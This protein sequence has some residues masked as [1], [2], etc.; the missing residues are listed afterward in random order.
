MVLHSIG[1]SE[2]DTLVDNL[3][4]V[5][6]LGP[7]GNLESPQ[8]TLPSKL[9]GEHSKVPILDGCWRSCVDAAT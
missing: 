6:S 3:G 2:E 5:D 4:P 8:T 1:A 9:H 7:V